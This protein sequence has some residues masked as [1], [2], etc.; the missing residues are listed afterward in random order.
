M[1]AT[2]L[3]LEWCKL[4]ATTA[5]VGQNNTAVL[6]SKYTRVPCELD[7]VCSTVVYV[8]SGM[9]LGW[10]WRRSLCGLG[11]AVVK[12]M[13]MGGDVKNFLGMRWKWI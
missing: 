12:C 5:I 6:G 8:F 1:V 7:R 11:G 4:Y 3:L 9:G 13:G 10:G 2:V